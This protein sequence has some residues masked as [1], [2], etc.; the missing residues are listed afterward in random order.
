MLDASIIS[1][2]VYILSI[3]EIIVSESTANSIFKS[4]DVVYTTDN[5]VYRYSSP[6]N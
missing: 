4:S 6:N 2:G 1:M 5:E 3:V